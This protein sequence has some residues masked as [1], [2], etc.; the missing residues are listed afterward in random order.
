MI[1]LS[2][3][4]MLVC[5]IPFPGWI[6]LDAEETLESI[7]S[8]EGAVFT[9][10]RT[11]VAKSSPGSRPATFAD[12]SPEG[13]T[14]QYSEVLMER[15]QDVELG[16]SWLTPP[17]QDQSDSAN[18]PGGNERRVA[19]GAS[20]TSPSALQDALALRERLEQRR[21]QTARWDLHIGGCF[22]C[23]LSCS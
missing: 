15:L 11:S 2:A 23:R 7:F 18:A 13:G 17:C 16:H 4:Q 12:S 9:I 6:L 5:A 1:A 19:Q 8:G 22:C 21:F 20:P 14:G 3:F 10:F